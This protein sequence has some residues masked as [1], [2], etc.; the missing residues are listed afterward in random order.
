AVGEKAKAKAKAAAKAGAAP[1]RIYKPADVIVPTF[2]EHLPD[3]RQEV[4]QYLTGV[5]RFDQSFGVLLDALTKSGHADDTLIVFLS[6]HGMS[7]PFSKASVYRNGTW[8]PVLFRWPGMPKPGTNR[9]DL[10]S[11][12]DILPT[13]LDILGV[14]LP[15]GL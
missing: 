3:I 1:T 13:I 14:A 10:V 12:V 7:F 9:T 6:D 2:L 11:S 5:A 8:S 15:V 4:A